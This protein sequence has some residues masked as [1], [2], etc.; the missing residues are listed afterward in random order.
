MA[1]AASPFWIWEKTAGS[2]LTDIDLLARPSVARAYEALKVKLA[3]ENPDDRGREKY[4][5]GK[6]DFIRRTLREALVW[7][8]LGTTV[9]VTIDRPIGSVHPTHSQLVYPINYGYIAGEIA[10][11]GEE[12][13]AYVLGVDVPVAAFTGRVI[14][15]I[16]RQ[17][18]VEDKL[19]VAP[20]GTVSHQNEIAE[21]VYF[22]ERFF[23]STISCLN[24]KSAGMIVCRRTQGALQ[25]LLL[26]QRK[27]QTWSFPKGH[28]EAFETEEQ[29]A[30]REVK[31]ETG[32]ALAPIPGFRAEIS[33]PLNDWSSKTVVLFLAESDGAVTIRENEIAQY[34]WVGKAEACSLLQQEGYPQILDDA[35]RW[36]RQRAAISST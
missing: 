35:E 7:R 16:N 10:P 13:D 24:R 32:L 23:H 18:D 21:A 14:G 4:L 31:E 9:T 33:Y 1:K 15:I 17:D 2:S 22:Q 3:N 6:F 28:M 19:V 20:E 25:V 11:D 12:L 34:R 8:Y 29:T 5:A 30:V 27:S 36:A 26:F